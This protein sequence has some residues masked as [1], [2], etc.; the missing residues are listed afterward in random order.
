[1]NI[2]ELSAV[3]EDEPPILDEHGVKKRRFTLHGFPGRRF[4]LH[5]KGKWIAGGVIA[6]LL[7]VGGGAVGYNLPDPKASIEYHSLAQQQSATAA[8]RDTAH[9][10]YEGIKAKYDTLLNGITDRENKV[11]KR[12]DDVAVAEGKLKDSEAVVK[13]REDAVSAVEKQ[14]AA[15]TIGTGTWV[16]GKDIEAGTYRTADAVSSDCYW[17]ILQSGTNGS[18]IIQNDIPGGGRPS[19]TLAA[20]QDFK[21]NRCGNW[22]KQ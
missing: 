20:G 15:N 3:P 9:T 10:D 4:T 17:A 11:K 18:N 19:V 8:D 21:S 6:A 13:K 1:M 5:R 14:K 2:D 22:T 16:V 7:L 12:E